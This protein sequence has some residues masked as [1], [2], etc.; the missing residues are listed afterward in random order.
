MRSICR[1][2]RRWHQ[3]F[4]RSPSFS[5]HQ[6][7]LQVLQPTRQ[8]RQP[9][10][11][12][13]QG[14]KPTLSSLGS[15]DVHEYEQQG[16]DA[17]SRRPLHNPLD[18]E[19]AALKAELDQLDQE[20]EIMKEGPFGP[21]S[22]FVRSFPADE[23]EE[24]LR[25]LEEDGVM[26]AESAD[27]ISEDDLEE[28]A[29]EEEGKKQSTQAKSPL[30]VTL[31]IPVRDKIYVKRFNTALEVAQQKDD[32]KEYFALWK[33]Y[34]RC[35]QRVSNFALI[36]PEDVWHFLWRSQSTRFYRP[37][38]LSMLGKDMIKADVSLED[39]E[40]I[41]YIDALQATG[42]V[43]TA[44]EIWEQQR[45]RLGTND[46][47][48]ELFW[49]TG[50]RLYVQLGKP[51]KAQ[52]LAFECY[53]HTTMI[54]PEVLV[55][56]ISAWAKSQAPYADLKTWYCYLELCKKLEARADD[57]TRLE[58]LGRISS[59]LLEVHRPSLAVAVFKD[60]FLLTASAPQNSLTMFRDL[61]KRLNDDPHFNEDLVTQI[62]LSAL[63]SFP[64]RFSNKYF[65]AAWIKWLLGEGR[66]DDA[67]LVVELMYERGAK[68]DA[69]PMNGLVAA[70]FRRG[71]PRD[72]EVAE[73]TAWAMIQSR[74]D[75][76]R[77]R[78]AQGETVN[79]T[80]S[81]AS[82]EHRR[83]FF[84]KRGA[85][86]ATIE[87]FSILLQHYTRR[88]DLASASQLTDVM[89]GSAQIKPNSFIMNHWLYASLRSGQIAEVWTKFSSLKR[90][91]PPDLDTFA[92]LWDTG[93][94]AYAFP[95]RH[96]GGFPE[97]R[98]LFTEM[99]EWFQALEA[100]KKASIRE[101]FSADLYEQIIRCFCLSSDPQ[102]T[103]C[104]LHG[105]KQSFNA[106]PH[107]EVSRLVI[108][109]VARAFASDF[110]PL[111]ARARGLRMK[112]NLQY[113]SAVK[114]LTEIVLAISDK[115]VQESDFDPDAVEKEESEAAQALRLN[116]LTAFLCL[117][118][119]KRM[120]GIAP[121][122]VVQRI[123]EV[124]EGMRTSM[125][126]DLLQQRHWGDVEM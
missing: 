2:S 34:L 63:V 1:L 92:A 41:E 117:V 114:T 3:Q 60:M 104:A 45:S 72:R 118:I 57:K 111:S 50:V 109:Q 17:S 11:A 67:A 74:L 58:I 10:R 30:K 53:E 25:A 70:W 69:G 103:L 68:P 31:S 75:L 18:P 97:V 71:S 98:T 35:Q 107:D 21:N 84:L 9:A 48:A 116:V 115:M 56:V 23:R 51:Q 99:Q 32:D 59:V 27:L 46:E 5:A 37:K 102:G 112:K 78:Q 24:L 19:A 82:T 113:Q 125:P 20:L 108:M 89:T 33:W 40:W 105:L 14:R 6:Q 64:R 52:R 8:Y 61:G 86:A 43:A 88:S 7:C 12:R 4:C 55:M 76:V 65:F 79:G 122:D 96:G 42:D 80:K 100:K 22:D 47:L 39:K 26:P 110:V 83:P 91:I 121:E 94:S 119:E 44:T 120:K 66:T 124:A 38:H 29:R 15:P 54:N 126:G 77:E 81:V 87:T 93:K 95:H 73:Q 123:L 49:I 62:G 106:L 28:L 13:L 85:P 90:S 16:E 36:I 101:D